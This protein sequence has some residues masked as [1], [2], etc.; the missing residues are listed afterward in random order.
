VVAVARVGAED[1]VEQGKRSLLSSTV[2][3]F[4]P[5]EVRALT[6]AD[7]DGCKANMMRVASSSRRAARG[8]A[9]TWGRSAV[10]QGW[11][12]YHPL[13]SAISSRRAGSRTRGS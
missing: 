4:S 2:L 9:A 6:G 13:C 11:E 1:R 7:I 8:K 12:G 10:K 3:A 5:L